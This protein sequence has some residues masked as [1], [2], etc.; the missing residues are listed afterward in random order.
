MELISNFSR[1]S[2]NTDRCIIDSS[3]TLLSD[4]TISICKSKSSK[5]ELILLIIDNSALNVLIF[6]KTLCAFT[7]SSQ[8]SSLDVFS[9]R[10]FT[11]KAILVESKITF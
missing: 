5:L 11:F 3:E 9:S 2:L 1:L 7:L 10:S 8:K 4:W 6:F